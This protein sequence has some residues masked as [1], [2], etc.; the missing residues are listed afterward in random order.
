[1][2]HFKCTVLSSFLICYLIFWACLVLEIYVVGYALLVLSLINE[3]WL[4]N[5]IL[6][7]LNLLINLI[8]LRMLIFINRWANVI[9]NRGL[10]LWIL[11]PI[12][13]F[14]EIVVLV[15]RWR[16]QRYKLIQWLYYLVWIAV[17]IL[18]GM[19]ITNKFLLDYC[20]MLCIIW[21]LYIY[22]LGDTCC[23]LMY[24]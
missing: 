11:Y 15:V 22:T 24:L 4:S 5:F 12:L 3:L 13:P 8:N 20:G 23:F 21:W 19:E 7:W 2:L 10:N 17:I 16:Y 18:S 9:L 1:M 6:V 14:L